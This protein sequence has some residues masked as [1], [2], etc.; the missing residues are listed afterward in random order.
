[1]KMTP[2]FAAAAACLGLAAFATDYTWTGNANDGG[3]WT[4]PGNWNQNTGYP[5]TS[6]DYARFNKP[7]TVLVNAGTVV[8]VGLVI[9]NTGA[10]L[11]TLN[12]TE[13]S[14]LN[15]CKAA[16]VNG[17]SFLVQDDCR[18]V[19]NL[20]V[21]TA[22][23]IDKWHGGEV[24]FT[25]DV[26]S[27]ASNNPLILDNGKITLSGSTVFSAANGSVG[28]GNYTNG[29]TAT[30]ELRDSSSL[31]AK[32]ITT[33]I[34]VNKSSAAGHIIQNGEGTAVSVSGGLA[35]ATAAGP[36]AKPSVYEL[37][38]GSLTV[39]GTLTIGSRDKARYVQTG[40]TSTVAA[41]TLAN[42]SAVSLRGG[43][44]NSAAAP[45]VAS[46][47]SFG[48][49]NTTLA[50]SGAALSTWDWSAYDVGPSAEVFLTGT[51]SLSIPR[52]CSTFD[53]G[54]NIGAGKT[55]AVAAGAVV[56]APIGSTNAWKVTLNEGSVLK[57]N[58]AT[59]R[60][61]VPL[62]LTVNG[63]GMVHMYSGSS[64]FGYGFRGVVVAHRLVVDGVEKAKGRY[65][66]TG[67][68]Y[69]NAGSVSGVND[70]ASIVVP[71]VWTGAGADDNW[72]TAA[73]WEGGSVPPS[74]S[75]VDISRATSITLD[76]DVTVSCLVA[77]PNNIGRK[78]TVTG[79]GSI[80]MG[81]STAYSC[82]IYIPEGYELVLDVDFKRS[83][84]NVMSMMGGGRLTARKTIPG[85]QGFGS[86][87]PLLAV[88]GTIALAGVKGILPYTPG[89]ANNFFNH[90]TPNQNTKGELLIEDGTEIETI[91]LSEG[92]PE[93]LHDI[94]VRQ[95]GGVTTWT[96]CWLH[97]V[98]VLNP[99]GAVCYYLEGGVMN[100]PNGVLLGNDPQVS[101]G[102]S[103]P[104]G[105][106]EMSGGTLNCKGIV[107]GCNQN[108]ARLYGGDVYLSGDLSIDRLADAKISR[109]V[110]NAITFYLGGVT[111]HPVGTYRTFAS[112]STICLT[113]KNGD[114]VFDV[115][116]YN[117][118]IMGGTIE[119]PGGFVVSGPNGRT[120]TAKGTYTNTGTIRLT[121]GAN[122]DI[123]TATLN[124][125]TKLVVDHVSSVINIYAASGGSS[126]TILK[127]PDV[128]VLAAASC[129]AL[130]SGQALTVKRLVVGG[131]DYAA[132]THAFGSGTVTVGAAPTSWVVDGAGD[133]SWFADGTT[134]TVDAATT[135]SSLAY[136]PVTEGNTNTLAGA[137]LTFADGANIHV[138]KGNTLVIDSDVVFGGKVTKT[139]WGEVVFNGSVSGCETPTA[140]SDGTDPRWLTVR[141]G[142]ATF[143]G[144][145]EG[146]RLMTCGAIDADDPP[147]ITLKENCR[148]QNYGIVLTAWNV[149]NAACRGETHQQGAIVDYSS[150]IFD[151]VNNK[152]NWA[153]THP[154]RGG[155]GR[156]VLDSG[157][158]RSPASLHLSFVWDSTVYGSFDFVQ[159]GGTLVVPKNFAFAREYIDRRFS[160]TLNGGRLE[161][162]GYFFAVADPSCNV[163][164][165][166]GG[167]YASGSSDFIRR[168]SFTLNVG[169][170]VTF[171][172]ASGKTLTLAADSID[173]GAFVKTGA[174]ALVLDGLFGLEGLG[175]EGGAV[176]LTGRTLPLLDGRAEL[177]IASGS[178][179]NLDYDGQA[180]FRTL[181]VGDR[182][183][184]AGVYSAAQ[185]PGLVRKA[186]GGEGTLRILE[187]SDPGFAITVR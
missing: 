182:S 58:E 32:E 181:R 74:G 136:D 113:G 6:A 67:N 117:L 186:L 91:R 3:L 183:R 152:S 132:G 47:C 81:D 160:Y 44:M 27:T 17:S 131:V 176:T 35:L 165:L 119:G 8:D 104:G 128:I 31:V 78:T 154:R 98:N 4:T 111:F 85:S 46:D 51:S 89:A 109:R 75:P 169:G 43:V 2:M 25:A 116:D 157:E 99:D 180:A 37:N 122:I 134:T 166:N 11:V 105:S 97:N 185:G 147:V 90:Y 151:S 164:N 120:F 22:M 53:M 26:T 153:L 38:A 65:V 15:P 39:G 52:S 175:V 23:R 16:T 72:N 73:N 64:S 148:V 71:Y 144:V 88:D 12:G 100:A 68:S 83:T 140:E 96:N 130:G 124:G 121:G 55:V 162:G 177:A 36:H 10:T 28:I 50:L 168:E 60:L 54:L 145:V 18:L 48:I 84:S 174:G 163:I 115:T 41:V 77:M 184:G 80:S 1:M 45:S 112:N 92:Y 187:G 107:G 33:G 56:S 103:R 5:Q 172:V 63:T 173:A 42:G 57:L 137:A 110:E 13:G 125:P 142:G 62:D 95:T 49:E 66:G 143:D 108:Y 146:V 86:V 114:P 101:N 20:P 102:K 135:L 40:G 61:A 141:E 170:E 118:A 150:A 9:V 178:K 129:L 133:L 161:L 156:Y 167:T 179:L 158:L 93:F 149:E 21:S 159:N 14:V 24:E 30:L 69:L 138:E 34:S 123:Q 59:A 94:D 79:T 70:A 171:E 82:G 127:S 106:L 155:Y 139:G 126:C 87:Y 19:V 7:A 76:S 29:D